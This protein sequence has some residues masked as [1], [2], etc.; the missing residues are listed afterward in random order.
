MKALKTSSL[1]LALLVT[2]A[3]G[4]ARAQ[5]AVDNASPEPVTRAQVVLAR[6]AFL[7]AHRWDEVASRWIPSTDANSA[8]GG[9]TRAE[10]V[11]ERDA[12]QAANLWD[13]THS[14]WVPGTA[15]PG[16]PSMPSRA[17]VSRDAAQFVATHRWNEVSGLWDLR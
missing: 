13:E 11:A 17:Q 12:Y 2:T 16:V 9:R 15:A 5:T 14:A 4:S 8:S 7:N 10:V 3:T 6:D 1:A